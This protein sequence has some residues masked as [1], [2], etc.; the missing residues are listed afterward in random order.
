MINVDLLRKMT[1]YVPLVV[2]L[3][4]SAV[5]VNFPSRRK[6][7][8]YPFMLQNDLSTATTDV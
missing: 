1:V 3:L 6:G 8:R 4:I 5:Y 2:V 7:I